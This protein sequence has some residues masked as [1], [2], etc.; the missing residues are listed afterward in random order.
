VGE[1]VYAQ[2][3]RDAI[4]FD[5]S[6][7]QRLWRRERSIVPTETYGPLAAGE[8][9]L[10]V[11]TT[12]RLVAFGPGPDTPRVDDPDKTPA[13]SYRISFKALS[14]WVLAGR[15]VELSIALSGTTRTMELQESRYPYRRW[16]TIK[17]P[18][19][20]DY[21]E[22]VRVWPAMNTRY[23]VIDRDTL[24][25]KRS[26]VRQVY[27]E[28][29]GTATYYAR[30]RGAIRVVSRLRMPPALRIHSKRVHIYRYRNRARVGKHVGTV[31]IRERGGCCGYRAVGVVRTPRLRRTDRF[32]FCIPGLPRHGYGRE[33]I[34]DPRCGKKRR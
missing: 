21:P 5:R 23:R 11:S 19:L 6:T 2:V 24:P 29:Y 12:D 26:P 28:L 4:A 16:R 1:V 8:D 34:N 18:M 15:S 7:G 17:R 9:R 3:G 31:P 32:A 10:L 13:S 14:R 30:G 27:L 33:P 22:S 25:V 20:G